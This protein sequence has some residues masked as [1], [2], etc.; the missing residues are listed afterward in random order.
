MIELSRLRI[1]LPRVFEP[2]AIVL[3]WGTS[4]AGVTLWAMFQ[5]LL[6]PNI[7]G[8]VPPDV[9]PTLEL[10]MALYYAGLTA[11]SAISGIVVNDFGKSLGSFFL[12][13]L[14]GAAITFLVWT[15]PA[16]TGSYGTDAVPLVNASADLSFRAFFPI[17]LFLGMVS[18]LLGPAVAEHFS[19]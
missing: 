4:L 19:S 16:L 15:I 12:A 10:R 3:G 1:L 11:V 18:S 7:L 9:S 8:Y 5:G 13:Y 6:L 14:L 2:T 17:P